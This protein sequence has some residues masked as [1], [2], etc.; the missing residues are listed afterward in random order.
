MLTLHIIHPH[1][2][3]EISNR[4]PQWKTRTHHYSGVIMSAMAYRIT[5]ISIVCSTVCSDINQ[6]KHQRSASL[7]S[8]RGI[9]RWSSNAENDSIRWHH[10]DRPILQGRCHGCQWTG[11]TRIQGNS[12]QCTNLVSPRIF[13]L[14]S[15]R[16]NNFWATLVCELTLLTTLLELLLFKCVA[17]YIM[18]LKW[19]FQECGQTCSL[20][21]FSFPHAGFDL[22]EID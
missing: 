2:G 4:L 18:M 8:V 16:D 15:I 21:T 9:H 1:R 13:Q 10:H 14:S 11:D 3:I 19:C 12:S 20:E 7:A 6:C 17:R 5:G 22:I